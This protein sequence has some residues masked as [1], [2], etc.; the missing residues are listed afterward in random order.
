MNITLKPVSYT[1]QMQGVLLSWKPSRHLYH[2][3][4][5]CQ[6][7]SFHAQASDTYAYV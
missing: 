5:E 6:A 2:A 4:K 1:E 7:A 3:M